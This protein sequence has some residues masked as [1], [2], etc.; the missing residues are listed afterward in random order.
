MKKAEQMKN[1]ERNRS[2]FFLIVIQ[3]QS[4]NKNAKIYQ[5]KPLK[6]QKLNLFS[7]ER[8]LE[9]KHRTLSFIQFFFV[10]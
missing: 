6:S 10:K 2:K 1:D 4:G 5:L 9:S 7:K 8:R 3:N